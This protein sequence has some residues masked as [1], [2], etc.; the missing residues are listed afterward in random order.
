MESRRSGIKMRDLIKKLSEYPPSIIH[1]RPEKVHVQEK[2]IK[3][4]RVSKIFSDNP[5]YLLPSNQD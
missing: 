3:N 5:P 1:P 2:V 4:E